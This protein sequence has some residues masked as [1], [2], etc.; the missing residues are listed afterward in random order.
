M[1]NLSYWEHK[2]FLEG[3]DHLVIGGGIVGLSTAYYLKQ[4][5]PKQRVV[6]LE[7][8]VFSAGASSKNAG[9]ACFGSPSELAADFKSMPEHEVVELVQMRFEGLKLLRALLGDKAIGYNPEGGVELFRDED[10]ASAEYCLSQLN[11]WNSILEDV[12]GFRPYEPSS[13]YLAFNGKSSFHYSIAINGEG[14][15]QTGL[16]LRSLRTLVG[17]SGV[18]LFCGA[19]VSAIHT[20][21]KNPVVQYL[22][23]QIIPSKLYICTNGFARELLPSLKVN[24]VRNQVLVTAP[25]NTILPDGTYHLDEGYVYFRALGKRL[26]IGG[27]RNKDQETESTSE[28]GITDKIQS[29]LEQF[30]YNYITQEEFSVDHRWSGIL[31]VGDTK[32]PIIERLSDRIY[33]GV[34]MGGMGVAIGNLIGKKLSE[35]S[36]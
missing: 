24:A 17:E 3:I 18:E 1:N 23:T 26:L 27:F 36:N 16:M 33:V 7:R 30:I 15:I 11:L 31:G 22:G 9:F 29:E 5:F 28:F 35:L 20:E 14:S 25:L 6:V 19:P 4:K 21:D 13:A 34:R 2:Y 10:R 12:I 32:Y 8:D